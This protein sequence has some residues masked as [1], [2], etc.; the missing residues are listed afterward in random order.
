MQANIAACKE[1]WVPILCPQMFQA[2]DV[3]NLFILVKDQQCAITFL[4]LLYSVRNLPNSPSEASY[5]RRKSCGTGALV[6][7]GN[8]PPVFLLLY[9]GIFPNI[10]EIGLDTDMGLLVHISAESSP[11]IQSEKRYHIVFYCVV[12]GST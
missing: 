5:S 10:H 8:P 3:Y 6:I 2:Q 4:K 12:V 9:S 7:D 1:Q 11:S